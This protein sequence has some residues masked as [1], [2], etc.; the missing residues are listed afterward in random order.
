MGKAAELLWGISRGVW[1]L[2]RLPRARDSATTA[3][4]SA[5]CPMCD[6]NGFHHPHPSPSRVYNH[7]HYSRVTE[8]KHPM[9][10]RDA[11]G[12]LMNWLHPFLPKKPK[13]LGGILT[14]CHRKCKC[15]ETHKEL[16]HF[17]FHS[18]A[19]PYTAE[20]QMQEHAGLQQNHF[21][22][23]CLVSQLHPS[24][25]TQEVQAGLLDLHA[26]AAHPLYC[27]TLP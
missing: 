12:Q 20:F 1:E 18:T 5:L 11:G 27:L 19:L 23:L 13:A 4:P 2:S 3:R 10:I 17:F 9:Q 21:K 26:P 15:S 22:K 25:L 16:S 24:N 14:M 8:Q 7:H 6:Y